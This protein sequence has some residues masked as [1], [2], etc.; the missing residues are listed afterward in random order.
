M[1]YYA[2]WRISEHCNRRH[3]KIAGGEARGYRLNIGDIQLEYEADNKLAKYGDG[4]LYAWETTKLLAVGYMYPS[5]RLC[6]QQ[7]G[8]LS[9]K[10]WGLILIETG[11]NYPESQMTVYV[12][13]YETVVND[14][15]DKRDA[16]VRAFKSGSG[17]CGS[18]NTY[19]TWIWNRE[20]V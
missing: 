7:A 1:P 11:T 19:N 13:D 5:A 10:D 16:V 6:Q 18:W 4:H 9:T 12:K 14:N 3:C 17:I 20:N 2:C 8:L 15:D